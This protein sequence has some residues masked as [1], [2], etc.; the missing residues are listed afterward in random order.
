MGTY[1]TNQSSP[2]SI[3]GQ[4]SGLGGRYRVKNVVK[5]KVKVKMSAEN[6]Q[7]LW[8]WSLSNTCCFSLTFRINLMRNLMENGLCPGIKSYRRSNILMAQ[9][10]GKE[11]NNN[12]ESKRIQ[13][14]EQH[15]MLPISRKMSSATNEESLPRTEPHSKLIDSN[16]KKECT[17]ETKI[18]WPSMTF[19]W[20]VHHR[21]KTDIW[22]MRV[23]PR[24]DPD[25]AK[26]WAE[27]QSI[28]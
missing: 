2:K 19:M 20:A 1:T 15:E 11:C 7:E 6:K 27:D 8:G 12:W 16:V 3:S 25:W 9:Q 28:P 17:S 5:V 13:K 26:P 4:T 18:E 21:I 22:M 10:K 23:G 14:P 24:A